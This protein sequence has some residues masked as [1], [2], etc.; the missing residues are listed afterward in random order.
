MNLVSPV[1]I[2][3]VPVSSMASQSSGSVDFFPHGARVITVP[4]QRCP[5][6]AFQRE[7]REQRDEIAVGAEVRRPR[8]AG[9]SAC[10]EISAQAL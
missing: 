2:F 10:W 8:R 9:L 1:S 5:R 6:P 7:I 4:L 3:V